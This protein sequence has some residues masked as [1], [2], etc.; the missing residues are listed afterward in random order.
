MIAQLHLQQTG[1][2]FCFYQVQ[3]SS[4]SNNA[5]VE[6]HIKASKVTRSKY[7]RPDDFHV[8]ETQQDVS[9]CSTRNTDMNGFYIKFLSLLYY[10]ECVLSSDKISL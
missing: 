5:S 10:I 1:I 6:L 3:F 4:S 2:F 7:F 8:T 9:S